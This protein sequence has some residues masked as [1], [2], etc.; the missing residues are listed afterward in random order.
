MSSIERTAYP[1]FTRAPSVKELRE[2]YTPTPTDVAF[3]ATKARGPA[4]KFAL[5]I[6]LKV[7]QRLHYFPDPQS[8]PGALISHIRAVMNLPND[9][10]PD[11]SPATLY[12]YYGVLREHLELN[13]QG[14]HARHVAAQAM[15]AAAQVMENPAD[16]I[17]AAIETLLVA[18]CELPAFS[19]LDRIAWRIRRLVNR[20]IYQRVFARIAEAEQQA[21][22]RLLEPD[23]SSPFTTFDRIKDAPK[24][25]TLTHLDEWLN[26]LS[27][28][29]SWGTTERFVEGVRSSKITCLAQE[30]RS[31]YPS[32]LLD[33]SAPRR[34][35]LLACLL[36][37]ATVSTKDEIIQM[38]LKRMSK[39]TEKAKLEATLDLSFTNKKW[40]RTILVRRKGKSWYRRQHL[41]TCVF[42][43]L[44]DELKSGDICVIGSEQFADYR[45]Q[46]LPWEM[47]E[48]KVAAYCQQLSLPATAEGLVEHLR[49]WLTEVAAEVDRTR[50]AN[51]ELMINEKGEPSLKRLKAKAQPAG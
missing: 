21:L 49:T 33:F 35:T 50:P 41:E 3:V 24:S 14:K 27:W 32:D 43:S 6:L 18:H 29:Q 20:G 36:S 8:I 23:E 17:N 10:V 19:T 22:S 28:L 13:S 15:H 37:Q 31:L 47:C 16:L 5:M 30:A 51:Q 46:L 34:L 4:Q 12:R 2:I 39:L 42:S 1:R 7:Y 38:F 25:A 26:R 44:A 9:L 48:P 40:Q 11:I 45:D